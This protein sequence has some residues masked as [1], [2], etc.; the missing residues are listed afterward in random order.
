LYDE[1]M[2]RLGCIGCPMAGTKQREKEFIRWPIYKGNYIAAFDR[3]LL[4]RKH[5]GK[6]DASWRLATAIDVYNWWMQYDVMPG[7][8]NLFEDYE[9]DT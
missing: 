2:H 6:Y 9:E 3:M 8:F 1:G 5:R 7:Q 4:E